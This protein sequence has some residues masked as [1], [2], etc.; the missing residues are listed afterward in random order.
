MLKYEIHNLKM[1][2][3]GLPKHSLIH[4]LEQNGTFIIKCLQT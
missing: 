4:C 2:E 1:A 3:T